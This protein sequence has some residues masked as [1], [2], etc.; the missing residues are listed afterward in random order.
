MTASSGMTSRPWVNRWTG[1]GGVMDR[2]IDPARRGKEMPEV[3]ASQIPKE[4]ST[5]RLSEFRK[6][7]EIPFAG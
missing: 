4:I 5:Q 7:A 6:L 1:E 3:R 2:A